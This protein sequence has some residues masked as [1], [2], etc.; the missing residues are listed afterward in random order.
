M[1]QNA[2]ANEL[3]ALARVNETPWLRAKQVPSAP[4][5][6]IRIQPKIKVKDEDESESA[7][8][9]ASA[10]GSKSISA[11]FR[12]AHAKIIQT[13][14]PAASCTFAIGATISWLNDVMVSS[15]RPLVESDDGL[16]RNDIQLRHW[17]RHSLLVQHSDYRFAR[18]NKQVKMLRY[19]DQEYATLLRDDTSLKDPKT[20]LHFGWSRE[21]TDLLMRLAQKY[22]LRFIVIQDRFNDQIKTLVDPNAKSTSQTSTNNT[23]APASDNNDPQPATSYPERSVEQLKGRFYE[24]QR[25]LM[26]HRNSTDVQDMEKKSPFFTPAYNADHETE[27][28]RELTKLYARSVSHV[29]SIAELTLEHRKVQQLIK[30]LK[31]GSSALPGSSSSAMQRLTSSNSIGGRGDSHRSSLAGQSSAHLKRRSTLHNVAGGQQAQSVQSAGPAV[32]PP[33][34]LINVGQ[35]FTGQELPIPPQCVLTPEQVVGA[36]IQEAS[37]ASRV[38]LCSAECKAPLPIATSHPALHRAIQAELESPALRRHK[39]MIST[40]PC[41]VLYNKLRVEV[42]QL[43]SLQQHVQQ[44]QALR[45]Q[46]LHQIKP[47][48]IQLLQPMPQP[49]QHPPYDQ[50]QHVPS[51]ES[52]QEGPEPKRRK[53][54]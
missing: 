11:Q 7:R 8:G 16:Q 40:T 21:E 17:V 5:V 36:P 38:L 18:F 2:S 30:R 24:I 15:A 34:F 43:V 54:R 22:D 49:V 46:L 50:L 25:L 35:A 48:M 27:R 26:L 32:P 39:E 3:Q 31:G 51:M 37:S 23:N 44:R 4:A 41:F 12:A 28:K 9:S 13:A 45:D 52:I 42:A 19:S 47:G 53:Q 20:K 1:N 10:S 29:K 33:G 6:A 14:L